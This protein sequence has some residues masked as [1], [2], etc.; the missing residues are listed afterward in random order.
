MLSSQPLHFPSL[1]FRQRSTTTDSRRTCRIHFR[2]LQVH[3]LQSARYESYSIA[4]RVRGQRLKYMLRTKLFKA[5]DDADEPTGTVFDMDSN[6][7]LGYL[8]HDANSGTPDLLQIILRRKKRK[9]RRF[10]TA[11]RVHVNLQT[12]LDFPMDNYPLVME[13]CDRP[14]AYPLATIW[15]SVSSEEGRS[16]NSHPEN[17]GSTS[18]SDLEFGLKDSDLDSD[19]AA[20]G[21]G[22]K[23][24]SRFGSGF[25][26]KRALDREIT[27]LSGTDTDSSDIPTV[28]PTPY[29][30]HTKSRSEHSR[31]SSHSPVPSRPSRMRERSSSHP[32]LLEDVSNCSVPVE[33][34]VARRA[35]E[36][37]VDI[38]KIQSKR[39]PNFRTKMKKVK[40]TISGGIRHLKQGFKEDEKEQ[41]YYD[42]DSVLFNSSS[43][44]LR[45]PN[46][47]Q[48]SS[49]VTSPRTGSRISVRH[50]GPRRA[51]SIDSA[52]TFRLEIAGLHHIDDEISCSDQRS[53]MLDPNE[54]ISAQLDRVLRHLEVVSP[55]SSPQPNG[56]FPE[57]IVILDAPTASRDTFLQWAARS[58]GEL[59]LNSHTCVI[60]NKSDA[61]VAFRR[62]TAT[63]RTTKQQRPR[64]TPPLRLCVL[65]EDTS[66]SR[67]LE[68]YVDLVA[69]Q[70][71]TWGDLR[72]YL[73][74]ICD[75][76]S[77]V[78]NELA[79]FLSSQ[80][81][82][83]RG[84]FCSAVWRNSWNS[85][86]GETWI[87]AVGSMV[88][89]VMKQYIFEANDVF[90]FPIAEVVLECDESQHSS[91][92]LNLPFI[93]DLS[94]VSKAR[95]VVDYWSEKP[96]DMKRTVKGAFS[97][98]HITRLKHAATLSE[99]QLD[100]QIELSRVSNSSHDFN[101]RESSPSDSGLG[102]P[103]DSG[104]NSSESLSVR[105]VVQ[106][107]SARRKYMDKL[108]QAIQKGIKHLPEPSG[109]R[110]W[111][112]RAH[113]DPFGEKGEE[114][115]DEN[116]TAN[117]MLSMSAETTSK[118]GDSTS[119]TEEHSSKF[120]KPK[121]SLAFPRV[122]RSRT[123]G[124]HRSH[125]RLHS[126]TSVRRSLAPTSSGSS[127]QPSCEI[128]TAHH[129]SRLVCSRIDGNPFT[130]KLDGESIG[131][132]TFVSVSPL[133]TARYN[134]LP[135]ATFGQRL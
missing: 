103:T 57:F 40:Q 58:T 110:G 87:P 123:R 71:R 39:F 127:A 100:T 3:A 7:D 22:F 21:R 41:L 34:A 24:G 2:Q 133:L 119:P 37:S 80:D 128:Q 45:K 4:V 46:T 117:T 84:L 125:S 30:N 52:R 91:S 29:V 94:I 113:S 32:P 16:E 51:R 135:V 131:G 104:F 47:R 88:E 8:H 73:L 76:E 120:P 20:L 75:V 109:R 86:W 132:V 14:S 102:T 23:S 55:Q 28:I 81:P 65:G 49:A 12:I 77:S 85:E 68:S 38:K 121:Y 35:S 114:G 70:P 74:P 43:S 27:K 96:V 129:V 116:R 97:M 79:S 108:Q 18:G 6:F 50:A 48:H 82:M 60:G 95:L 56:D 107:H 17:P 112:Q 19:H 99:D 33:L 61:A 130:V 106:R 98:F 31:P 13:S 64:T 9:T 15:V 92:R 10:K 126:V 134:Q 101:V 66:V 25:K 72:L 118:P 105:F 36:G 53:N 1:R 122:K 115:S 90:K 42:S 59:L 124:K 67:L 89:H 93:R 63:Y 11:A 78:N 62:I 5:P 111:H 69:S 26:K 54:P 44:S 83:Y